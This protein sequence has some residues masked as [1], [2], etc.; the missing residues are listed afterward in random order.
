[1]SLVEQGVA[2]DFVASD[3]LRSPALEAAPSANF[4]NLRGDVN[5]S[6]PLPAKM[7]RVVAYYARLVLYA[8]TARPRV[9]HVLWNNKFEFFDRTFLLL[10]YKVLGKRLVQ[11]VH[12]VNAQARDGK[13]SWL[14]RMTLRFQYRCY[15]HLLV[16]TTR[17]RDEL[18]RDY[19]VSARRITV[20]PFGIN[21]SIPKT[22]LTKDEARDYLG[23]QASDQAVLFFGNI[24]PYKGL[25]Y[26]VEAFV[27]VM[28]DLPRTRL[29]IAGRIKGAE[30]Y[31]ERVQ[32]RIQNSGAQSRI[33]QHI[34]FIP[35][36]CIERYF[37]AA[38]V[39][40]LP[41]TNVF[42]S[43]VLFL[44]YSF[45]LPA[46]ATDVG[47]LREEIAEGETGLVC[48]AGDAAALADALRRY[49]RSD[50]YVCIEQRRSA[51]RGFASERYSWAKVA[52]RCIEAYRGTAGSTV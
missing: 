12:N 3:E 23:L 34:R 39:L 1:M 22:S 50:M 27:A 41:Y 38:D 7:A 32:A 44:A 18:I 11:T 24:A 9:F 36:E 45:G 19:R 46:I 15:D 13:D 5:P 2:F 25:E 6:A 48:V 4:I 47:S 28:R 37:K 30:A 17:M 10:Y 26:L 43:G 8:A 42:Q 49:F 33:V 52:E 40:A 35:E 51:L 29:I 20:V 31:W 21:D 14:N 16:H